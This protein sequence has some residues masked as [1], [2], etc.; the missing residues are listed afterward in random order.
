MSKGRDISNEYVNQVALHPGFVAGDF[1]YFVGM[2]ALGLDL[3]Q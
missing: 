2:V 3:M 1:F